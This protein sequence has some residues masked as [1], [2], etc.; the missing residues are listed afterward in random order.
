MKFKFFLP[1]LRAV[2]VLSAFLCFQAA[3]SAENTK[4][5]RHIAYFV[6]G[7]SLY[8]WDGGPSIE[9]GSTG[10]S[11]TGYWLGDL[12]NDNGKLSGGSGQF[13]QLSYHAI[14]PTGGISYRTDAFNP[15]PSGDFSE[16]DF[17]HVIIMPSNFEQTW[18]TPQQ[19]MEQTERVINYLAVKTPKTEILIYEHWPKPSLLEAVEDKKVLDRAEWDL[20]LEYS[21]GD[22]H[23][24]FVEWQNLILKKYP[25]LKIRMIP[26]GPVLADLLSS[27][28]YL[29][30]IAYTDVYV[31]G[32]PHGTRTK[33]FLA[34]LVMYRAMFLESPKT[35]YV[36]P[37]N[38]I[39]KEVSNNLGSVIQYIDGR[40]DYYNQK[41]VRVYLPN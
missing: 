31:D 11:S 20:V 27:Q 32:A 34:A 19:Y 37:P 13:G 1:T 41:G 9:P 25:Q 10:E 16:Q 18:S 26:V 3:Q 21:S 4:S 2:T 33:Y 30:N 15:W 22:Y 39:A 40:L 36:A 6:F 12:A 5:N 29:K 17:S 24:W 28:S 7:H 23:Q 8:T 14:P 35:S 38:M